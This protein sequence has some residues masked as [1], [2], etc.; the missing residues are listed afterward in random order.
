LASAPTPPFLGAFNALILDGLPVA[1][2]DRLVAIQSAPLD[3][4]SRLSGNSPAV[5]AAIRD[6]AQVF[7]AVDMSIKV[8]MTLPAMI[9]ARRRNAP[10]VSWSRLDGC[11]CSVSSR[12][13][14]GS[15]R[16]QRRSR[17]IR[18]R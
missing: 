17:T 5:Y 8:T 9:Q 18:R 2:A 7:D 13:A 3:N 12:C 10:S 1:H 11:R 6:R 16:S 4:P 15:S 14:A